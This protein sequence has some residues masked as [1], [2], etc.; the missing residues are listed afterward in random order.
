MK[1]TLQYR[2]KYQLA[3]K[4]NSIQNWQRDKHYNQPPSALDYN[5]MI[6][7]NPNTAEILIYDSSGIA[8]EMHK[9]GI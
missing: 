4:L 7:N 3:N 6:T 8:R 2:R 5:N 9:G 1:L